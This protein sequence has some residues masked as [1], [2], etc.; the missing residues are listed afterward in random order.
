MKWFFWGVKVFRRKTTK[1]RSENNDDGPQPR[2]LSLVCL[3][4]YGD[5]RRDRLR[6]WPPWWWKFRGIV[7]TAARPENTITLS[8]SIVPAGAHHLGR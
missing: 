3:F 2:P 1:E 8:A 6:R 4:F 7:T 5:Y